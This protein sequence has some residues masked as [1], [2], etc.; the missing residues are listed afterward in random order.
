MKWYIPSWNGDLRLT[1]SAKNADET[2]LTIV[3]PTEQERQAV[4]AMG[5]VF[6][7]KGW[8]K[9]WSHVGPKKLFTRD[10]TLLIHAPLEQ[11]G[12]IVAKLLKPQA[13]V[14]TAITFKDGRVETSS[15]S[16]AELQ[17]LS[18]E[19]AKQPPEKAPEAA[20]TV[21]R[22]TPSC[23]QCVEGSIEPAREVLLA[24]LT[25]EQHA[26]WARE[27]AIVVR[28]GLS[29]NRYILAHRHSERA[30][31][32]GRIC[33]DVDDQMVVHFHDWTVPPEEEVLAAKLILEHRE[34][35]LRNEATMLG[36]QFNFQEGV[37]I[38]VMKF[39]N[40]FGGFSDGVPDAQFTQQIGRLFM[41]GIPEPEPGTI[42][43]NVNGTPYD[44]SVGYIDEGGG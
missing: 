8:L 21:K 4:N 24:F 23:P 28:G 17:A 38:N 3:K 15:G 32:Q 16:L 19:A 36:P 2:E 43:V 9:E 18:E 31:R 42:Q 27:R 25:E 20:V 37:R 40:P 22:P 13:A 35:W 12:P 10:K 34:P 33:F 14:L 39:K 6:V 11:V 5:P 29:G 1:P 26:D 41:F 7:E 30:R 44:A